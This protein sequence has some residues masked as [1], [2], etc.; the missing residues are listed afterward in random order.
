[1]ISVENSI[2]TN[3]PN[4]WLKIRKYK[5]ILSYVRYRENIKRDLFNNDLQKNI[6]SLIKKF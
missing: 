4:P 2:K 3:Q 1:M 6:M 5:I